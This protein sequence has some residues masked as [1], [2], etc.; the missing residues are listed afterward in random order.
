MTLRPVYNVV[1]EPEEDDLPEYTALAFFRACAA[2][3]ELPTRLT[4]T[5][6]DQFLYRAVTDER[7]AVISEL[8]HVLRQ[9]DSIR[10][11]SVVQFVVDGR[12]FDEEI[13]RLGVPTGRDSYEDVAIDELFVAPL[14]REGATHYV[15]RK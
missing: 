7:T 1:T 9:T 6:L 14:E 12:L 13:V 15:A 8:H 4:V 10:P 5:D 3:E 11:H 2:D